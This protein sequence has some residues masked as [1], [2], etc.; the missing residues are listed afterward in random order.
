M[1]STTVAVVAFVYATAA[2]GPS[3]CR[4]IRKV[5]EQDCQEHRSVPEFVAQSLD[6]T[7]GHLEAVVE[8]GKLC[9][10]FLL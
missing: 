10:A 8:L 4:R 7:T 6:L 9:G 2:S 5:H 3:S 1:T